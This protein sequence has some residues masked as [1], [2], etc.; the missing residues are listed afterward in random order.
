MYRKD[1]ETDETKHVINPSYNNA[2]KKYTLSIEEIVKNLNESGYPIDGNIVHVPD[3]NGGTKPL[4]DKLDDIIFN[5]PNLY[6][7]EMIST[8]GIIIKDP[9]FKTILQV[10]LFKNNRNI[11]NEVLPRY[12]K[13]TRTSGHTEQDKIADAEWNLRWADGAKEIPITVDDVNNNAAFTCQY[14]TNDNEIAWV[15]RTYDDYVALTNF[16]SKLNKIKE[17]NINGNK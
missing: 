4:P 1:W 11:T 17:E 10:F 2:I 3:G 6:R 8:N 16:K 12:F 13:W 15:K 5:S 14:V 7:L 9:N